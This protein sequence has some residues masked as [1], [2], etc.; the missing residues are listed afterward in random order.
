MPSLTMLRNCGPPA[1]ITSLQPGFTEARRLPGPS[2]V[3]SL[4]A[5]LELSGLILSLGSYLP[6]EVHFKVDVWGWRGGS[7][8]KLLKQ[9][10]L[11]SIPRPPM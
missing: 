1:I 8:V 3:R 4:H 11:S 10:D 6:L 5:H 7:I 9:E 2:Q